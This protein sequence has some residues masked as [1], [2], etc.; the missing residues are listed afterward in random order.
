MESSDYEDDNDLQLYME[1]GT[2]AARRS[3]R[4]SKTTGGTAFSV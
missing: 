1:E 2:P 4:M 3:L